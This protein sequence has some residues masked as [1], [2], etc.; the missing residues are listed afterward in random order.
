MGPKRPW[1]RELL[2][3]VAARHGLDPNV[4]E[5]IAYQESAHKASAFRF[6]PGFWERYIKN[7]PTYAGFAPLRV[8]SSYG[9]MQVMYTTAV[10]H[11][12]EQD[13]EYL[14]VVPINLEFGCRFLASLMSWAKGDTLKAVQA[15]NGGRGNWDAPM[16]RAYGKAVW[17]ILAAVDR[18]GR[19]L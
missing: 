9:L 6:E 2:E 8:A 17:D 10:E 15:Y 4:V 5:A 18:R 16:P 14:F 7:N 3:E 1:F 11:G 13:P 12:F 19:T